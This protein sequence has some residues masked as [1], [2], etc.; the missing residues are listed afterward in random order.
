MSTE[1]RLF[2]LAALA[3]T[4]FS[5]GTEAQAAYRC[6]NEYRAAPCPGGKL[7]VTDDLAS[8]ADRLAEGRAVAAREK[9]LADDMVRD[10]RAR[11]AAQRPAKAGSLGPAATPAPAAAAS[12]TLKPKKKAKAKIR[13]LD[14]KDFVAD[15]PRAKPR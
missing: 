12:A 13:V 10:R 8:S 11:D 9:R 5:T 15:V 4:F 2:A 7:V 1:P 6:G 3:L 14:E